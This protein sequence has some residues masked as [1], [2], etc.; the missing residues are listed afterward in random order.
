MQLKFI[1]PQQDADAD[2]CKIASSICEGISE[3]MS[4]PDELTI[5]FALMSNNVYGDSTLDNNS[6]KI[7]RLN[8]GLNVS[9]LMIPLIHELIHVNQMHE[10]KL[11]ITHDGIFIWDTVSYEVNLKDIH[12]KEYQMLPWEVDVRLRQGKLLQELLKSYK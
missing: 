1:V 9:D 5:E 6:K 11:M 3:L 7:I 8:A 2:K 10:G 4:L 12:Y